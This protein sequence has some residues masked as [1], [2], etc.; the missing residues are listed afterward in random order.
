MT[1]LA[2]PRTKSWLSSTEIWSLG[3]ENKRIRNMVNGGCW[4]SL[5][6]DIV[7]TVHYCPG[8]LF[9]IVEGTG[10]YSVPFDKDTTLIG[11]LMNQ[12]STIRGFQLSFDCCS[13]VH[14][15][16]FKLDNPIQFKE[17]MNRQIQFLKI[18]SDSQESTW[19]S[20]CLVLGVDSAD[21]VT[22]AVAI[23][24][25]FARL[26]YTIPERPEFFWDN[27]PSGNCLFKVL[28]SCC[29]GL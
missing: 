24:R 9:Y 4:S 11:I 1:S 8:W 25:P 10:G 20:V 7:R 17:E 28:I 27:R 22:E 13:T 6:L 29:R 14:L 2:S 26:E 12:L 19:Q 18:R 23:N 3:L 5:M 16:I 21:T 15:R